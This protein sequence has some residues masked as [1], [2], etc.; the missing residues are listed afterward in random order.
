MKSIKK[1]YRILALA[2]GINLYCLVI[3]MMTH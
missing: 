1:N 3:V 2:L